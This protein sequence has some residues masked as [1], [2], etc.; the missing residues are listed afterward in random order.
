M[1]AYWYSW[2]Y[3]HL[4]ASAF[5]AA[6]RPIV[7]VFRGQGANNVTRLDGLGGGGWHRPDRLM[8]A[9]RNVSHFGRHRRLLLPSVRPTP[10]SASSVRPLLRYERSPD[11]PVVLSE[12]AVDPEAGQARACVVPHSP[13]QG[14][15]PSG[16]AY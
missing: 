3:G 9:G 7:T 13:A 14:D 4:P 12:V 1:N 16:L 5:V 11:C 8:V 6:W 2:G 15:L 10:S